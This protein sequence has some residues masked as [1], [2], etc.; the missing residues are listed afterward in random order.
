MM[1]CVLVFLP[2]LDRKPLEIDHSVAI[3]VYWLASSAGYRTIVNSLGVGASTV[4]KCIH[5]V[6]SAMAGNLLDKYVKFHAIV[7]LEHVMAGFDHTC[8]FL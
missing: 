4:H 7:D 8:G 1:I 2:R 5:D 3:T 6:C